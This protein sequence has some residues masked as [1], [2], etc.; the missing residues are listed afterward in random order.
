MS[1]T[2]EQ[3]EVFE[4]QTL[5]VE[6]LPELQGWREKQQA[7]AEQNPFISCKNHKTYTEAK[8]RRTA[9][10]SARTSIQDQE[11]IIASQLKKFRTRVGEVSKELIEITVKHEEK[12]QVEVKRYELEKEAERL[13]KERVEKERVNAIKKEIN[14][15]YDVWKK[16]ISEMELQG[17]DE[18]KKEIISQLDEKDQKDFEEFQED[19]NEKVKLL[20]DQFKERENYLAEKEENRIA[21]EKLAAEKA[22]LER[23][24][25]EKFERDQKRNK[26][27]K[28]YMAFIRDY[29]AM[30]ELDKESYQKEL[31]DVKKAYASQEQYKAEEREK[32]EAQ[33]QKIFKIRCNRLKEVGFDS[34]DLGFVN[35][36]LNLKLDSLHDD[37]YAM[38]AEEFEDFIQNTKTELLDAMFDSDKKFEEE[39][40]PKNLIKTE[41]EP[42]I[43]GDAPK[44]ETESKE[45]STWDLP[46][47]TAAQIIDK[48]KA[49]AWR[50]R[51]DWTDPRT[52]IKTIG[53]LCDKLRKLI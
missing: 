50:I 40:T 5:K 6:S 42:V 17:V 9:L 32:Q 53:G 37:V 10:V 4:L 47:D 43:E 24:Q 45:I 27:M 36:D 23:R 49:L 3:P 8:K 33:H 13:E 11:K 14:Q 20:R 46:E 7:I 1:E 41:P 38:D 28:P 39:L 48:I 15:F 29:P 31:T 22:K 16:V 18:N 52:E 2:I 12:Q 25:K 21:Q 51:N 30:L 44:P 19:F 35:A 34:D 26:E